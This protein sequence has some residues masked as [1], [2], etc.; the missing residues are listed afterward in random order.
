M[1]GKAA[2]VSSPGLRRK[3]AEKRGE[4]LAPDQKST[5]QSSGRRSTPGTNTIATAAMTSAGVRQVHKRKPTGSTDGQQALMVKGR[6]LRSK[7]AKVMRDCWLCGKRGGKYFAEHHVFTA[8]E[9]PDLT[10]WLCRGSHW[11]V[12]L[13]SRYT[14]M[15]DDPG[16]WADLI[17][18][19][20]SQARLPNK[21]IVVKFE[22]VD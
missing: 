2:Q 17:M 15:I 7:P 11:L 14:K 12:N 19:A 13:L 8:E 3:T 9:V 4:I 10:V 21:R 20:R 6:R 18:L 22:E 5:L 1:P 16:K